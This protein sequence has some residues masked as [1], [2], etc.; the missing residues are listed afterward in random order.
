MYVM[1]MGVSGMYISAVVGGPRWSQVLPGG[2]GPPRSEAEHADGRRRT[3]AHVAF[4]SANG[5]LLSAVPRAYP[6]PRQPAL[7]LSLSIFKATTGWFRVHS[8]R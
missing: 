1:S 8:A 3:R 6:S 4:S 7:S 2:G 5:D